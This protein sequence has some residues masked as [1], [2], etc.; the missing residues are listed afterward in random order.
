MSERRRQAI[1]FSQRKW[2][3]LDNVAAIIDIVPCFLAKKI[4]RLTQL[5]GGLNIRV[6]RGRHGSGYNKGGIRLVVFKQD[7]TVSSALAVA[8]I[9]F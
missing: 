6:D 9:A 7:W 8:N 3:V 1:L 4:G 5:S 2:A